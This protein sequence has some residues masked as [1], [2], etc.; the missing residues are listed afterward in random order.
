MNNKLLLF[1][2]A[3]TLNYGLY[4][5]EKMDIKTI[6]TKELKELKKKGKRESVLSEKYHVAIYKL[7]NGNALVD[8]DNEGHVF[9]SIAHLVNVYD[10]L[11][12]PENDKTSYHI[13]EG[14]F[15]YANNF[16]DLSDS[17]ASNTINILGIES[18]D[19][20]LSSLK[21]VDIALNS[22]LNNNISYPINDIYPGLVAVVGK[23]LINA[24]AEG[25]WEMFKP[26][27]EIVWEPYIIDKQKKYYNPFLLVYKELYEYYLEEEEPVAIFDHVQVE[28]IQ[29]Q[30]K[31]NPNGN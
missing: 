19:Y 13:L 6:N 12:G 4:S 31:T 21:K 15:P 14:R 26:E 2:L 1:L 7:E 9:P 3:I 11:L 23:L 18:F 27:G 28:L 22:I 30:I 29:H 20:K 5:Q 25:K 24:I 17:I 8:F 16:V 10:E